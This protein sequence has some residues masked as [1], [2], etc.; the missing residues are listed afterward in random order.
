MKT[1]YNHKSFKKRL[2]YQ[3]FL[4]TKPTIR[5]EILHILPYF[6]IVLL[7]LNLFLTKIAASDYMNFSKN[8]V[9]SIISKNEQQANSSIVSYG[10]N[11]NGSPS[12][13]YSNVKKIDQHIY[14]DTE[15]ED[16]NH[17]LNMAL[18]N[19]AFRALIP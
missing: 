2:Q 19:T 16:L 12:L 4:A 14:V 7:L 5:R 1:I 11:L 17:N 13:D 9:S 6:L 18:S 15:N 3:R 8:Y 10:N